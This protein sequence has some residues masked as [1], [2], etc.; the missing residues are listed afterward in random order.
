MKM[1]C[2]RQGRLIRIA[3]RLGIEMQTDDKVGVQFR[4]HQH[5][6]PSNFAV[7]IKQNLALPSDGVLFFGIFWIENVSARHR[8]AIFDENFSGELFEIVRAFW[9]RGTRAV[10]HKKNFGAEL[11]QFCREHARDAQCE[12]AFGHR[13]AVADL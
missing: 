3:P 4:V 6:A 5:R 8:N 2:V 9:R 10:A 7:A 12:I 1:I 11:T 13:L